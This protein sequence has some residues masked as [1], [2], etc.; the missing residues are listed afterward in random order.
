MPACLARPPLSARQ[1]GGLEAH[2][3]G[4]APGMPFYPQTV[5]AFGTDGSVPM[6][7]G[8]AHFIRQCCGQWSRSILTGTSP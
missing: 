8:A 3:G 7:H 2:Y 6:R 5:T 4:Q 1:E